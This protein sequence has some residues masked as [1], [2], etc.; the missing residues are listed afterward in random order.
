M[1][2]ARSCTQRTRRHRALSYWVR[3][4]SASLIGSA[5]LCIEALRFTPQCAVS[6]S[7]PSAPVLAERVRSAMARKDKSPLLYF[8][9]YVPNNTPTFNIPSSF[10]GYPWALQHW[11]VLKRLSSRMLGTCAH[12]D[13]VVQ[14]HVRRPSTST[15]LG[16]TFGNCAHAGADLWNASAGD[17]TNYERGEWLRF[18]GFIRLRCSRCYRR[19]SFCC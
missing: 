3:V 18:T 12:A 17:S 9:G 8:Y 16:L 4:T 1:C 2:L 15:M 6:T 13:V 10:P 19:G 11:E 5:R 7:A 14:R